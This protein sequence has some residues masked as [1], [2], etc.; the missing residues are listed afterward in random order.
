MLGQDFGDHFFVD[1]EGT[2]GIWDLVLLAR[3]LDIYAIGLIGCKQCLPQLLVKVV[4]IL[5]RYWKYRT[6]IHRLRSDR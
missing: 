5:E 4:V 1:D 6:S 3:M 2:F